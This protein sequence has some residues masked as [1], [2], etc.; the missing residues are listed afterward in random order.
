MKHKLF[1]ILTFIALGIRAQSVTVFSDTIHVGMILKTLQPEL[2]T[3]FYIIDDNHYTVSWKVY[4]DQSKTK[5]AYESVIH[6]DTCIESNYWR[7]T[8]KLK[9]KIKNYK[10]GVDWYLWI[11]EEMYCENG[12][13]IRKDNPSNKGSELVIN[14]YCNGKK[15]N[16]FT[17]VGINWD[18]PFTTYFENGQKESDGHYIKTMKDG[19]WKYWKENGELH[20]IEIYKDGNL[21]ETKK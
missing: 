3:T 7:S 6:G 10:A 13:L 16:E 18:G 14:Y 21:I 2:D 11:Y 9:K 15:K 1:I 5:L 8:G 12:Q 19:E 20:F 4:F 17:V